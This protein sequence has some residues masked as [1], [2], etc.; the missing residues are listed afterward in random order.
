MRHCRVIVIIICFITLISRIAIGQEKRFDFDKVLSFLPKDT[1]LIIVIDIKRILNTAFHSNRMD[2][3]KIKEWR[4]DYLKRTGIDPQEDI[5]RII[6]SAAG[7]HKNHLFVTYGKLDA[8]KILFIQ[9]GTDNIY[10]ENYHGKKIYRTKSSIEFGD[11]EGCWVFLEGFLLQGTSNHL[12]TII[13]INCGNGENIKTNKVF[14][15]NIDKA[16][17]SDMVWGCLL[18]TETLRKA[19]HS[20]QHSMVFSYIKSAIIIA[21]TNNNKELL[22][23]AILI[24][25]TK[26]NANN[27]FDFI[28]GS[29]A[30]AKMQATEDQQIFK[31][32]ARAII[33][34]YN[35]TITVSIPIPAEL[36]III[37]NETNPW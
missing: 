22:A 7:D 12:K 25:H 34:K 4:G 3:E 13:D 8:Q 21:N 29:I 5:D 2:D 27:L 14:I 24:C 33:E 32:F 10:E 17:Q 11:D 26:E 37:I 28:N 18:T 36:F 35:D 16:N 19:T 1:N 20:D 31:F 30:M 23:S 6:I 15:D 9:K